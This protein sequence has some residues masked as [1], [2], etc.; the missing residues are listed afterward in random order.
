MICSKLF[1]GLNDVLCVTA[2][3]TGHL[4]LGCCSLALSCMLLL[5]PAHFLERLALR[6]APMAP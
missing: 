3:G 5:L 4:S 1:D 2:S 6:W